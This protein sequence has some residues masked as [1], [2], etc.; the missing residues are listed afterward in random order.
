M[1][2]AN[3][4]LHS[5]SDDILTKIRDNG[6]TIFYNPNTNEFAIKS[7]DGYIRTYFKPEDGSDYFNRV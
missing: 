2:G 3:R 7:A 1:E 4:L 5:T 6:D